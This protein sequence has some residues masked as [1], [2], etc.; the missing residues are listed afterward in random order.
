MMR[1]SHAALHAMSNTKERDRLAARRDMIRNTKH[2]I[3]GSKTLE[4]TVSAGLARGLMRFA[5][6]SGASEAELAARSGIDPKTLKDTDNRIP[7][8]GYLALIHVGK[9]LAGDPAL[10]LHA[11]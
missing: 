2:V 5:V 11:A 8:A 3:A 10:A 4:P 1:A 6:E 9:E 7:L